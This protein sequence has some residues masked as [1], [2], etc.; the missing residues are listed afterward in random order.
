MT[1]Y[2]ADNQRHELLQFLRTTRKHAN[3]SVI[4]T[5][6]RFCRLNGYVTIFEGDEAPLG[7]CALIQSVFD[8]MPSAWRDRFNTNNKTKRLK[9]Q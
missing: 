8:T 4:D 3:M 9:H 6:N 5:V 7:N 2:S 1:N